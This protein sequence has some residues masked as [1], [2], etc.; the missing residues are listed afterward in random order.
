MTTALRKFEIVLL[1]VLLTIA[2]A[3]CV[4]PSAPKA[5]VPLEKAQFAASI[6]QPL[7]QGGVPLVL[8]KNP[9]YAPAL[10]LL[11]EAIPATFAASDLTPSGIAGSLALL[12]DR[13]KLG[14]NADAQAVVANLISIAVQ[15]YAAHYGT[16]VAAATD[17]GIALI[18]SAFSKGLHDGVAGWQTSHGA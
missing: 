12:N 15:Q 17:P 16:N 10:L 7:A 9:Q 3:A 11:S 5:I 8:N 2:I 6:I 14:L 4:S 18:L 13:A 1:A